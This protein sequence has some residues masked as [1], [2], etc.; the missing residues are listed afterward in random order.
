MSNTPRL[1]KV[2]KVK[3]PHP[4]DKFP[5]GFGFKPGKEIVYLPATKS[6]PSLEGPEWEQIFS[7]EKPDK[8]SVLKA[9]RFDNAWVTVVNRS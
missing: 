5:S 7:N 1:R 6:G 9:P 3:P 4:L 8:D 2:E